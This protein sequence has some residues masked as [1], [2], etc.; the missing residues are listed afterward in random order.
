M[1]RFPAAQILLCLGCLAAISTQCAPA[2]G[3]RVALA[4]I[5]FMCHYLA[6][7]VVYLIFDDSNIPE[8]VCRQVLAVRNLMVGLSPIVFVDLPAIQLVCPGLFREGTVQKR[9]VQH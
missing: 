6:A 5:V 4:L 1:P 9:D 7:R 8:R 2:H 3:Q